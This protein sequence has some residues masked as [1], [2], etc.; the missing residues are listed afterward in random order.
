MRLG[1][2][3]CYP[4]PTTQVGAKRSNV[5]RTRP[6]TLRPFCGPL[7][8]VLRSLCGLNPREHP[9]TPANT[10]HTLLSISAAFARIR[11]NSRTYEISGRTVRVGLNTGDSGVLLPICSGYAASMPRQM[12]AQTACTPS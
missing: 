3:C 2:P 1:P 4:S 6:P 10:T 12:A 5:G 8:S 11:G 9:R 7:R